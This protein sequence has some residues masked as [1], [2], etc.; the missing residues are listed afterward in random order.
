MRGGGGAGILIGCFCIGVGLIV[1]LFI[2]A[3]IIRAAV[4]ISNK[5]L[6]GSSGGRSS[7]YDDDY[8][9]DY[10]DEDDYYERPARRRRRSGGDAIPEPNLGKGMGIALVALIVQFVVGFVIGIAFAGAM[11]AAGPGNPFNPRGGADV[12]AQLAVNCCSAI[13]GFFIWAGILTAMLPTSFARA[14]LVTL[15]IY[16]IGFVIGV[17]I[18]VAI[19]AVM[20]LD[21]LR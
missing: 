12:G 9:D 13:L 1:A 11:G 2:Y 6:G 10:D 4:W 17:I 18:V 14:S 19:I 3:L 5:C 7:Y 16:I 8:D 20:G 15:F 21:A